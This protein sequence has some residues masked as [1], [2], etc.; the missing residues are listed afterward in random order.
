M[1]ASGE[2]RR[3]AETISGE[4]PRATPTLAAGRV[5]AL[6]AGGVSNTIDGVVKL[7][8]AQALDYPVLSIANSLFGL[9]AAGCLVV[10]FRPAART[11][12]RPA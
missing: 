3:F 2:G 12:T 11:A 6:G 5:I 7:M 8:V 10:A 1:W 4:G 9:I